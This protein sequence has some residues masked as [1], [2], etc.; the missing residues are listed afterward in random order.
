MK[1]KLPSIHCPKCG[2]EITIDD[3]K[4]IQDGVM[5]YRINIDEKGNVI[6]EEDEFESVEGGEFFHDECGGLIIDKEDLKKLG[7]DY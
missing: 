2:K 4:Y 5:C 7:I 6:Y 1:K 3:I